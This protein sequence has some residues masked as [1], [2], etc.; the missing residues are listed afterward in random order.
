MNKPLK[1]I[2]IGNST[3]VIL[4]KEVLAR[5][6]VGQG[7]ALFLSE[8]PEGGYRLT[9]SDPDFERKM[10]A[11]EDIMRSDRDILRVLSK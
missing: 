3:G 4:P 11:A 10:A 5:L 7:D 9:P 1:L 2:P 6:R 8:A